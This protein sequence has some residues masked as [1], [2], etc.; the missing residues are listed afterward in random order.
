MAARR[1]RVW[2]VEGLEFAGYG[3]RLIVLLARVV[4][5]ITFHSPVWV[6]Y[7]IADLVGH[8]MFWRFPSYRNAVID[9]LRHVYRFRIPESALRRKARWV[10]R[11]SAR[12]FWDLCCVPHIDRMELKSMHRVVEGNWEMIDDALAEGHGVILVTGHLGAFDFIGQYVL[13]SRYRPLVLTAPTVGRSLFAGVTYL[14]ASRGGRIEVASARSLRH[15]VQ[16]LR[17]GELVLMVVD[18]DFT[19]GGWPVD[20]FGSPTTLPA[21]A[22]KLARELGS[23]IIPLIS[24]RENVRRRA[25]RFIFYIGEPIRIERT[26]DRAADLDR[27]MRQL[28]S[29]LEHYIS[30]APEQW[31]TFQPVWKPESK[32]LSSVRRRDGRLDPD[33]LSDSVVPGVELP[34]R[35]PASPDQ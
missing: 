17:A 29:T 21:G 23:P 28:A 15:V 18:R 24:L 34:A 3:P 26:H 13:T 25:R 33:E 32:R 8:W 27:G 22:V 31:V 9:N 2:P 12:N 35:Q 7:L 1:S 4:S 20:F 5:V 6:G 11:V 10:F 30:L 16:A 14:R 19:D